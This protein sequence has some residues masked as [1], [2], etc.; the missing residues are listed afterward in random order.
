MSPIL[1]TILIL[2]LAHRVAIRKLSESVTIGSKWVPKDDPW[3]TPITIVDRNG[4]YVRYT[5]DEY[6]N[7]GEYTISAMYVRITFTRVKDD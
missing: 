2:I 6:K 3:A 1:L 5:F 7:S 4:Q